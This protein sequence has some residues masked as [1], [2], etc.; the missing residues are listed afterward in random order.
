MSFDTEERTL[1]ERAAEGELLLLK[2]LVVLKLAEL[3]ELDPGNEIGVFGITKPGTPCI[4]EDV[5]V[6]EQE[7]NS[8]MT[9]MEP[10]EHMDRMIARG[11]M[12]E[13]SMR[14]WIHTHPGMGPRPSHTDE[15]TWKE[16]FKPCPWAFMVILGGKTFGEKSYGRLW[17][18]GQIPGTGM[19]QEI[20]VVYPSPEFLGLV[21]ESLT[22]EQA[23]ELNEQ[24][25]ERVTEAPVAYKKENDILLT[26]S[27][28]EKDSGGYSEVE[29]LAGDYLLLHPGE[30]D[31]FLSA[32]EEESPGELEDL[33]WRTWNLMSDTLIPT[34][35]EERKAI[36]LAEGEPTDEELEAIEEYM[37]GIEVFE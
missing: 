31:E 36:E 35:E 13:Q 4:V 8:A 12:P 7:V 29:E 30:K 25:Q 37:Q 24:Y 20:A 23:A 21:G 26:R 14:V 16:V 27:Y 1:E 19:E 17:C 10:D 2:P 34:P 15:K 18:H 33:N 3:V 32:L 5:E 9:D 28:T 11:V 6:P 22:D